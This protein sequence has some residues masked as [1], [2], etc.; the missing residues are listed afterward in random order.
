MRARNT[1]GLSLYSEPISIL[2]AQPPDAPINVVNVPGKTTSYQ[3][4]LDW[5]DAPYDGSSPVIDYRVN[6]ALE[7]DGIYSIYADNIISTFMPYVVT[8]LTPGV[9]YMFK[10]ESRNIINYSVYSS[11]ITIL[12]AQVADKPTDLVDVASIT[13]AN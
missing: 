5:Q 6:I 13:L 8:G 4:G 3:I 1:V 11:P 10:I 2:V 7:S 9:R 12:A